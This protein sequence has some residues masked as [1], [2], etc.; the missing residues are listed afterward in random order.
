M[1]ANTLL[2]VALTAT[3]VWSAA[4]PAGTSA[5]QGN[6][7]RWCLRTEPELKK[8]QALSN[9]IQNSNPPSVSLQCEQRPTS[10]A[11]LWE[12]GQGSLDVTSVR[13]RDSYFSGKAYGLIPVVGEAHADGLQ[14]AYAGL[15][16]VRKN[17]T[18]IKSLEDLR[19]AR[20][21]HTVVYRNAGWAI[22]MSLLIERG[23]LTGEDCLD[24]VE[25]AA[26]FF[27][28]SCAATSQRPSYNYLGKD[29]SSLCNLCDGDANTKCTVD[30]P[31]ADY[32][33]AIKC[34]QDGKG[35]IAFTKDGVVEEVTE[36]E[37]QEGRRKEDFELLCPDGTRKS[38]EEGSKCNWGVITP[39]G[40]MSSP[41]LN[42]QTRESFKQ[43]LLKAKTEL[44]FD[45]FESA[46]YGGKNLL[47]SDNANSL[48]EASQ[49][50]KEFTGPTY[51]RTLE[52]QTIQCDSTV[53]STVRWCVVTQDEVA[54]CHQ[55]AVAF[56]FWFVKPRVQCVVADSVEQCM[57]KIRDNGADAITLD[58]G[59]IYTAGKKYNLKPI[60]YEDYGKSDSKYW[61]VAVVK[62]S[63]QSL[64]FK[65]LKGKN[66]CHTGVGRTAGWDVPIS[67]LIQSGQLATTGKCN[68]LD[69][70]AH[71]FN[72][73]CAPGAEITSSDPLHQHDNLCALCKGTGDNKC[74]KNSEEPFF[75]YT[76]A[77]RCLVEGGGDVAFVNH[78]TTS[79]NTDGNNQ[80]PWAKDLKSN[81][82]ELLC[83]DGSRKPIDQYESCS[84]AKVPAHAVV[85]SSTKTNKET[86]AFI[87]ALEK[88]QEFYKD[89]QSPVFRMF[90][91]NPGAKDILFR[92]ATTQLV[93]IPDNLQNYE[94]YLGDFLSTAQFLDDGCEQ[95]H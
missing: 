91:S 71:F 7:V 38:L 66:S 57:V 4:I 34:L 20:S 2:I 52:N 35:D 15:A 29:V 76:G 26:N 25:N 77:F 42:S 48:S 32:S 10:G 62:K 73:S 28:A 27:R 80:D 69:D 89:D 1:I 64:T 11:C 17:N 93:R 88:G 50:Y 24:N 75:G 18:S 56:E 44:N 12:V 72:K 30:D 82:F 92:D 53:P 60:M 37:T 23:L 19:G 13:F 6:T 36:G 40:I 84:L 21:C 68:I 85:T 95:N 78:L 43:L 46:S 45:L 51:V 63:D 14:G 83:P 86:A 65:N 33:G 74:A 8:C 94:S 5:P 70:V 3:S 81:D 58:G 59:E 55:M 39:R 54:K 31:Y 49:D 67:V 16:V 9:A 47:F 61:A 79:E 41:H 87:H 22:P 90:A